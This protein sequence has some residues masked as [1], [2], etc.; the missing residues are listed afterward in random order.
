MITIDNSK[1]DQCGLCIKTCHQ[2]C[3]KLAMGGIA[4]DYSTCS[5]CTH[6]IAICP[7]QALC[8]N[9]VPSQR[10]DVNLLPDRNALKEF[11][12]ARRSDFHYKELSVDRR[13]LE[14]IARIGKYAPTNN[15][16]IDVIIVDDKKVIRQ[17]ELLCVRGVK[18]IYNSLF[19][20][21]ITRWM[22]SQLSPEIKQAGV[23]MKSSIEK[24]QIF[25][26]APV[27]II[28]I[29]DPRIRLTVE[30]VQYFMYNMQL[31]AKSIGIGSRVSGGGKRF[32]SKSKTAKKLLKIPDDRTIQGI[33]TMGYPMFQYLNKVEGLSPKIYYN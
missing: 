9:H 24:R 28:I 19:K 29:A 17:L 3:I 33:L 22:I 30:S 20:P 31:Y 25:H 26:Q 16:N 5:T 2:G 11:F 10:I 13:L 18:R 4:L 6:C 21:R 23:K 8:W 1:C 12:K 14:E 7:Q 27:L 15:Y 32:L